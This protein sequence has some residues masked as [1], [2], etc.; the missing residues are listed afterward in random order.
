MNKAKWTNMISKLSCCYTASQLRHHCVN[1]LTKE[2]DARPMTHR[3]ATSKLCCGSI[4]EP[5]H[6]ACLKRA[7]A[8]RTPL[9]YGRTLNI[10]DIL[11][12]SG[13]REQ[14]RCM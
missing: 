5:R 1:L 7:L 6:T 12:I 4:D 10:R 14:L 2:K 8:P 9:A 3:G 11:R 13:G